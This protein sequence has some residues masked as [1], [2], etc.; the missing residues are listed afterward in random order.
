MANGTIFGEN[1]TMPEQ[2]RLIPPERGWITRRFD[3]RE[4]PRGAKVTTVKT[5]RGKRVYSPDWEVVPSDDPSRDKP[6][7]ENV[8]ANGAHALRNAPL[9]ARGGALRS[10]WR[11]PSFSPSSVSLIPPSNLHP[12]YHL[13]P[14]AFGQRDS[15]GELACRGDQLTA[16]L[17]GSG[18]E[19]IVHQLRYCPGC[20]TLM[21]DQCTTKALN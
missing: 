20:D 6:D 16:T 7:V 11:F 17:S 3:L 4:R 2:D 5:V 10:R 21:G 8:P 12:R 19:L 13:P 14:L 15:D 18:S 9:P 1:L